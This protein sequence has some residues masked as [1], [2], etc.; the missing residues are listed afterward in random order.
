MKYI[1]LYENFDFD[2]FDEEEFDESNISQDFIEYLQLTTGSSTISDKQLYL[3]IK[4]HNQ[5]FYQQNKLSIHQYDESVYIILKSLVKK[6]KNNDLNDIDIKWIND[7]NSIVKFENANKIGMS[8][9]PNNIIKKYK[10]STSFGWNSHNVDITLNNYIEQYNKHYN[11]PTNENFNF[12]D[13]EWD[14]EE[15]DES[16]PKIGDTIILKKSIMWDH[17]KG[18]W[19]ELR[20]DFGKIKIH[21]I[22]LVSNIN[23]LQ[24]NINNKKIP[25]GDNYL[26]TDYDGYVVL[27]KYWPWFK[28]ED[29]DKR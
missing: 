8:T 9:T 18:K 22:K 7:I 15:W 17:V 14:D 23:Y 29:W 6:F 27:T 4:E 11:Y 24:S 16:L 3:N 19:Q 2:D 20:S 1:K 28:L 10:H 5:K 13:E 26:P 25:I 21:D 12:D